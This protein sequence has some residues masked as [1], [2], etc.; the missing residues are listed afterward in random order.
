MK[1]YGIHHI[2]SM[3]GHAQKNVDFNTSVLGLRLVK[4][5]LNYDDYRM[6]HFY[7]GNQDG[8]S[9][10]STTFP[11]VDSQDGQV[12]MGQVEATVYG[13]MKDSL[14]FWFNRLKSFGLKPYFYTRFGQKRL[15][16]TDL[17]NQE[18]ELIEIEGNNRNTWEFNG[19]T[20]PKTLQGIH[21]ATLL[22]KNPHATLKL[23]TEIFGYQQIDEDDEFIK[24]S[25]HND[26]GGEIYLNKKQ[27]ALGRVGKGTVHHIALSVEEADLNEWVTTLEHHGYKPT[28]IKDRKYF[29]SIYFREKGG[30]LIELATRGPGVLVDE[31][32]ETLGS[33][34]RIPPHY[35]DQET[36]V[37]E[38]L[39]PVSVREI[40]AFQT[41][42]YRNKEE[43]EVILRKEAIM[44]QINAY[45]KK[46]S[47]SESEAIHLKQLRKDFIS[48]K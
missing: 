14:D 43:Y 15:A 20:L 2:S 19:V 45:S 24:L 11:M 42:G 38:S 28:E 27:H 6:Y 36:E 40:D 41:Y 12:G 5:T 29:K 26:L 7:F 1:T 21:G 23:F 33:E 37:R 32:Y 16:F 34:L 35:T 30:I 47:L 4:K 13:V 31:S 10:L 48:V 9:G 22:S 17:D 44:K 46:T 8:S 25:V 39:M 18:F 3:V